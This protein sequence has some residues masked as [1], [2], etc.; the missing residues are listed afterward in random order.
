MASVKSASRENSAEP[1]VRDMPTFN[2]RL[3]T[4][5]EFK[6]RLDEWMKKVPSYDDNDPEYVRPILLGNT[7]PIK[8]W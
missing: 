8:Q 2:P 6:K 4:K 3:E 1:S 5:N 7:S